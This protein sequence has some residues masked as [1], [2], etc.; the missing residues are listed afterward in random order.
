MEQLVDKKT[1]KKRLL[2]FLMFSFG[3]TW[4]IFFLAIGKG[5]IW[6]SS[7]TAMEQFVGLG[8]LMPFAANLITRKLTKEGFAMT[9]TD[10]LLLGIHFKNGKWKYYIFA[11]LIPWLYLECNYSLQLLFAPDAYDTG[12]AQSTGMGNG[13]LIAFPLI[14]ISSATILSFAALGE[15]EGWRGYM[16]PK[17]I[18]IMGFKK[19]LLV[20]GVIWGFWHAPLTCIGHN[21]GTDY[22]GFPYVG[23]LMMCLM[24]T[25][26]GILLTYVTMKTESIWPAV[27]L[28]A[29]NNAGPSVLKFYVNEDVVI[30][31][32]LHPIMIWF[33]LLIPVAVVDVLILFSIRKMKG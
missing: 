5:M 1:E 7:D 9:G 3:M 8:M 30:E 17:L 4:V 33:F 6:D 11:L 31:K 23:I 13:V 21:F 10:S 16:M 29:V 28:H 25:L 15:E 19:A 12:I 18:H 14:S 26:T 2:I 27:F 32:L 24:C 20:G 22:P